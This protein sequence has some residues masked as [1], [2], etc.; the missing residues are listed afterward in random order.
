MTIYSINKNQINISNDSGSIVFI[1]SGSKTD[2]NTAI[3]ASIPQVLAIT[4]SSY[5]NNRLTKLTTINAFGIITL[6]NGGKDTENNKR[7]VLRYINS[8]SFA[9][10]KSN[11]SQL[12]KTNATDEDDDLT[13]LKFSNTLSNDTLVDIPINSNDD[14][15]LVAYR[16]VEALNETPAF[17]N[18]FNAALI[19]DGS[20]LVS[21]TA[22]IG[23]MTIGSGFK[24][25][26]SASLGTNSL[27]DGSEGK[28]TITSINSSSVALPDFSGTQAQVGGMM[29]GSSFKIGSSP[30]TFKYNII[31]SGSGAKN[32][33]FF[34]GKVP[35]ASASLIQRIDPID[36]ISFEFMVPSQSAGSE[37]DL[38]PLY[39]SSSKNSP[40]VLKLGIGTKDPL[41]N[42]DIRADEFQIQRVKEKKGLKINTEG[43]IESFDK[44]PESA[45]TGSEF[46]LNYSRGVEITA[47]NIA[48]I[49][50]SV[51]LV[52]DAA[53]VSFFNSQTPDL[54]AKIIAIGEKKGLITPPNTGDTLGAMRWVAQS[55]SSLAFNPR[56][57]GETAVIKA[58]VS[59]VNATG[60][61]ADL[62]FSVAGKEGAATQ[63]FLIDAGN[64]HQITGSLNVLGSIRTSGFI[65]PRG[66]ENSQTRIDFSNSGVDIDFYSNTSQVLK[67]SNTGVVFNESSND[68]DFRIEGNNNAN[69]FF[70]DAGNDR[71]GIGTNIPDE[72]LTVDGNIKASGAVIAQSYI[73]SESIIVHSV[74]SGSTVFGDS[75]DDSHNF[76]GSITS[77]GVISASGNIIAL[78][79][80]IITINGGSF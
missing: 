28:F 58:V 22:S 4:C 35:E 53:A 9:S 69:L 38:I 74:S 33:P 72:K 41:T 44:T 13:D 24:V 30:N 10:D 51:P 7:L 40:A 47:A 2:S 37:E 31:T 48:L 42:V 76:I 11:I 43:N 29:I 56:G 27:T 66:S 70:I 65:Q 75:A 63:R 52:N 3:S 79:S 77:S 19:N 1:S 25:R 39:I 6:N 78:S 71:V 61:Q 55:G 23:N 68:I 12:A 80:D 73:V 20:N 18:S 67:L 46:I 26:N 49:L 32:Q 8:S 45:T 54:Q 34:E 15:F 21:L 5:F 36:K 14:S 17:N 50:N 64:E 60:V 62:I 59:D 57:T 16:T